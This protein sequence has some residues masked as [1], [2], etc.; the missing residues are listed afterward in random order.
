MKFALLLLLATSAAVSA[1][2]LTVRARTSTPPEMGTLHFLELSRAGHTYTLVPPG[3]GWR[4]KLDT[5]N[6]RLQFSPT[7][8]TVNMALRFTTNAA[9]DV[10][11]SA[12]A[13]RQ[14]AAPELGETRKLAVLDVFSGDGAGK[15]ADFA[16][17]LLGREMR[18]RVAALPVPGGTVDFVLHCGAEEFPA[19][20]QNLGALLNTFQRTSRTA[21]ETTAAAEPRL[22][23]RDARISGE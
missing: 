17:T 18:C 20:Q 14:H 11:A 1:Q 4:T 8:G 15:A 12:D 13:L 23:Q 19:A 2:P 16:Y 5:P 21:G 6:E 7:T 3:T 22:A 9:R 10:L